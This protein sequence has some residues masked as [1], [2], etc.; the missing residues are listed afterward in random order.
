LISFGSL[1][2]LGSR[3]PASLS[4]QRVTSFFAEVVDVGVLGRAR[5]AEGDGEALAVGVPAQVLDHAGGELGAEREL[6]AGR[7][8]VQAEV[9][10]AALVD[11]GGHAPAV[12]RHGE[13]VDVPVHRLGEDG[14][15]AGRQVEAHGALVLAHA[16]VGRDD[17]LAVGGER[18]VGPGGRRICLFGQLGALAGGDVEAPQVALV[19]RHVVHGE[20]GGVVGRPVEDAPAAALE[21]GEQLV[22]GGVARVDDVDVVVLPGPAGRGVR[23][24]IAGARPRSERVLRLAVGQQHGLAGG[25]L[26]PPVLGELVAAEVLRVDQEVAGADRRVAGGH[27][28]VGEE[29]ELAARAAGAADLVNLWGVGEP[30]RHDH[31]RLARVPAERAGAAGLGVRA[32]GLGEGLRD[33]RDAVGDQAVG[34]REVVGVDRCGRRWIGRG[35]ERRGLRGDGALRLA[36][37]LCGRGRAGVAGEQEQEGDAGEGASGHVNRFYCS[38]RRGGRRCGERRGCPWGQ[39][40]RPD[41]VAWLSGQVHGGGA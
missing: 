28:L 6:A 9:G 20:Q 25:A 14:D 31:V 34:Q 39:V 1:K 30:R 22:G 10:P 8:L 18:A 29:G 19:D 38:S 26:E 32:H 37:L 33:R 23:Q 15:L 21:L 11:D 35:R 16:V 13:Q 27:D 40:E 12:V 17:R 41:D 24:S 4:V 7:Q 36:D 5:G 2:L 3:P